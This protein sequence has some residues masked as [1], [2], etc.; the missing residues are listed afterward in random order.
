MV[1]GWASI[2]SVRST[3]SFLEGSALTFFFLL[4]VL[5]IY[6]HRLA[7][8]NH[9]SAARVEDLALISFAI[10]VGLEILGYVYGQRNDTLASQLDAQ[11]RIKIATLDNST[12]SLKA[13]AEIALKEAQESRAQIAASE[14]LA[15]HAEGLV[16]SAKAESD[17]ASAKAEGFRLGIANAQESAAK[18]AEETA[19][20]T[21]ENLVRQ[22]EVLRLRRQMADREITPL[23]R[24]NMLRVLKTRPPGHIM[25]QSLLAGG[26]EALQYAI[27]IADVFQEGAHWDVTQPT[28]MGSV[29]G[30]P[31]SGV[32][33]VGS[34]D[35][36]PPGRVDFIAQV[37]VAGEIALRPVS[38][39]PRADAPAGTLEIWVAGRTPIP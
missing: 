28:G 5:E 11:Q 29:T 3:H 30:Y 17:A 1:P 38:V 14:A 27:A 6:S 10:A 9:P 35:I 36:Y 32:F 13:Q 12:Q 2:D 23:Q 19:R 26:R 15:K 22:A 25:V 7:R 24:E 33:L 20:M 39:M 37:L 34:T 31:V 8:K 16:A 21:K 4:V 18:A